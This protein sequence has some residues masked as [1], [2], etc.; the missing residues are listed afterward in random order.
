M[1]DAWL[2]ADHPLHRNEHFFARVGTILEDAIERKMNSTLRHP[3]FDVV[4]DYRRII[5]GQVMQ[6]VSALRGHTAA[7]LPFIMRS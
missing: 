2:P 6:L 5:D 7:Y 1:A 3:Q 4:L